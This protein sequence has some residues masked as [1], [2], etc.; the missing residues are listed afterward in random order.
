MSAS[1]TEPERVSLP[2]AQD[3]IQ[4]VMELTLEGGMA[5]GTGEHA[6]TK[7]CCGWLP[8][9]DASPQHSSVIIRSFGLS[10]RAAIAS[11][12]TFMSFAVFT[13]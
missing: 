5:F 10:C 12:T 7:L 6:T 11:F 13:T 1:S 8:S 9:M 4:D 3:A 2:R